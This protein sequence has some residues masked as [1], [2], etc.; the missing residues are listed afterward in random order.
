M[1][2]KEVNNVVYTEVQ[3]DNFLNDLAFR[4]WRYADTCV[5]HAGDNLSEII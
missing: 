3:D 1:C 5:K 2:L 4:A